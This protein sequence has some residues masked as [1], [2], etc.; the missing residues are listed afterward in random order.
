MPDPLGVAANGPSRCTLVECS[1]S[2]NRRRQE[3]MFERVVRGSASPRLGSFAPLHAIDIL[4]VS[5]FELTAAM[6]L[7]Q[8]SLP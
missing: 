4:T 6:G 2:R 3:V 7:C 5:E 8:G 1:C